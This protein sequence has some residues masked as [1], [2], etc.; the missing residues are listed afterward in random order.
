MYDS[1]LR[2]E[3]TEDFQK[4][5][6]ISS[7][8]SN[9]YDDQLLIQLQHYGAP[10]NLLDWITSIETALFFAFYSAPTSPTDYVAVFVANPIQLNPLSESACKKWAFME[11]H[12]F[13]DARIHAQKGIF[14][15]HLYRAEPFEKMLEDITNRYTHT[16]SPNPLL[17]LIMRRSLLRPAVLEYLKGERNN[18]EQPVSTRYGRHLQT[19]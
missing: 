12:N 13:F 19:N 8:P 1:E 17:K 7:Y 4:Q 5:R 3:L 14:M 6:Q 15:K 2:S 18:L 11:P 16:S 9:P 10:T